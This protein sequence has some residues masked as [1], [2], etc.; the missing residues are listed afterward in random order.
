MLIETHG[1]LDQGAQIAALPAVSTLSFGLMD[2]VSAHHGVIPDSAMRS[3]GQ[4][5]HPLVR[6]AKP[7]IAAAGNAQP[8]TRRSSAIRA[9]GTPRASGTRE[10]GTPAPA[11]H[12]PPRPDTRYR[13]RLHVPREDEIALTAQVAPTGARRATKTRY[14]TA[15]WLPPRALV[16]SLAWSRGQRADCFTKSRQ[17]LGSF[18]V[19]VQ[20]KP[21]AP[22]GHP[23]RQ[24]FHD[25]ADE[26]RTI[27]V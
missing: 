12:H 26:H 5:N 22:E 7:E 4:F 8:C 11:E 16:P 15:P 25:D 2:F 21:V 19:E 13:D 27:R 3:P 6:R 23:P 24:R 1:A 18:K 14:T 17:K 9:S 20:Q 10:H